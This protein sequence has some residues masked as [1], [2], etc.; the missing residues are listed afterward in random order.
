MKQLL[1]II[2]FLN[3]NFLLGQETLYVSAKNGLIVR[4]G[5]NKTYKQ[6]GKL[7]YA[8]KIIYYQN[9]HRSDEIIDNGTII[10]G[11]WYHISGNDV[12]SNKKIDG[13]VFN[14]FL[15][16]KTLKKRKKYYEFKPDTISDITLKHFDAE[17]VYKLDS[18]KIVT[19]NYKPKNGKIIEPDSEKD[20]GDR[21]ILLNNK[22]EILFK[23]FGAG[24]VYLFEPHFYKNNRTNKIVIVCQLAY[25]YCF[26]GEAFIYENGEI[27]YIGLLDVDSDNDEKCLIDIIEIQEVDDE[28]IFSFNSGNILLEPGSEDILIKSKGVNYIYSNKE[29]ILKR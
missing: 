17:N 2:V 26:G 1:I 22:N 5:P 24:D 14:G 4:S 3:F 7:S 25:E 8:E 16:S 20:W 6:V 11:E 23:S 21:L 9:T 29:L 13:Y 12:H 18:Q 10:K 19:G 28:I 15:T 27:S